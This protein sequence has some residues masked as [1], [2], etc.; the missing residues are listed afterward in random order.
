[1]TDGE[2]WTRDVLRDLRTHGYRPGAWR[3]FITA[4]LDRAR[5]DRR[6]HPREHRQIILV[7]SLGACAWLTL[8]SWSPVV[9][10]IGL[11]WWIAVVTMLDW[12][13]GML[14]HPEGRPLGGLGLPN[15][16]SLARLGAVPILFE[17]P[18]VGI[19]V[20]IAIAASTDI[21]DGWV[22]RARQ[23]VSRLGRW[24]DGAADG[25]VLVCAACVLTA[26][27]VLPVWA[28]ALV[29]L[30]HAAQWSAVAIGF[31]VRGSAPRRDQVVSARAAGGCIVAGIAMTPL[32]RDI[33]IALILLGAAGGIAAVGMSMRRALAALPQLR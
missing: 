10:S 12:H 7:G 6:S 11:A 4:S 23:R 29:V 17:L 25:A 15:L 31:F 32:V 13:V 3:T 24:L 16:L 18:S 1:M 27:D 22:A 26:R 8:L 19:S 28:T 9:A 2:R 33:G 14:Q 20:A 5:T 21:A 30:R